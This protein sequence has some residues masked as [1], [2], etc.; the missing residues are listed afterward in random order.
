MLLAKKAAAPLLGAAVAGGLLVLTFSFGV[1]YEKSRQQ[2]H[3]LRQLQSMVEE[4]RR[5]RDQDL[6]IIM[7]SR[8]RETIVRERVREVRVPVVTPDCDRLGRDWV[9]QANR[10]MGAGSGGAPGGLRD[11]AET[12]GGRAGG[13]P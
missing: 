9:S 3:F 2:G 11:D 12:V 1:S 13:G 4:S 10:I 7:G 6:E 8:D 5:I